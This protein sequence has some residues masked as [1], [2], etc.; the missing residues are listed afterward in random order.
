MIA[1]AVGAGALNVMNFAQIFRSWK[2]LVAWICVFLEAV[3]KV[4]NH[5]VVCLHMLLHLSVFVSSV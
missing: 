4:F 2:L 1:V 5:E 3:W